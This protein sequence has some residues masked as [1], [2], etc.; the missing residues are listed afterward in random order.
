MRSAIFFFRANG[1]E[2]SDQPVRFRITDNNAGSKRIRAFLALRLILFA[3]L[4]PILLSLVSDSSPHPILTP[5]LAYLYL[6]AFLLFM[7]PAVPLLIILGMMFTF[8]LPFFWPAF[9]VAYN[10]VSF[11]IGL[12]L[13]VTIIVPRIL[14]GSMIDVILCRKEERYPLRLFSPGMTLL[15]L[16]L[17]PVTAVAS[18]HAWQAW[19]HPQVRLWEDNARR[20]HV[21]ELTE[22]QRILAEIWNESKADALTAKTVGEAYASLA[23]LGSL[24]PELD[25]YNDIRRRRLYDT[26]RS[27]ELHLQNCNDYGRTA[28]KEWEPKYRAAI[29]S[30]DRVPLPEGNEYATW[31]TFGISFRH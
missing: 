25:F 2:A 1:N 8:C 23:Q 12:L 15:L 13:E 16:A 3:A 5:I 27:A 30:L 20:D 11:A 6:I 17:L 31:R 9:S 19:Y 22:N 14:L 7:I 21:G 10:V 29:S 24:V 18:A 4:F 26:I 28:Y